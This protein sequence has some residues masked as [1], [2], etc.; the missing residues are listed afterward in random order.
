MQALSVTAVVSF[1]REVLE[2]NEIF[3]D[4]WI[5]G[6]VSSFNRSQLGHRYF[7]LR[8]QGGVLRTVL[9]RD[10]MAG[11]MLRDGDRVLVHGK[12]TIYAQRGDLQFVADFVRPEG[13]GILAARFEELRLRLLAEGLFAQER[14]RPLPRFP[15]TVGVV[16]SPSGAALQDVKQVLGRRWPVATLVVAPAV[17]QGP[18]APAEIAAALRSLACEP[19]LDLAIL[20]RGGGA[21]E[22]LSAF[23]SEAVARAVF[24]FPVPIISGVGHETDETIADMV[25][26]LRAPTPSAAAERAVPEMLDVLR[27]VAGTDRA[28]ASALQ[29][30]LSYERTRCDAVASRMHRSEP[31][32]AALA[33]ETRALALKMST[34]LDQRVSAG[35]ARLDA[36]HSSLQALDPYATLSRGFA[37]VQDAKTRKVVSTTRRVKGGDRLTVSVADG[38][39]WVEVS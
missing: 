16:T 2:A 35:A 10:T 20:A 4:L 17:V 36:V 30:A 26:D 31:R 13:V 18:E 6:E 33:A 8:D 32:P 37:I 28:M 23:N 25:A 39:F 7:S 19:G 14:K 27:M 22:D 9:F 11:M 3:S 1:L 5:V 38:P 24:A 21:A 15:L 34:I 29:R 12:L